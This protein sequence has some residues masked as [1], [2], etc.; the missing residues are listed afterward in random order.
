MKLSATTPSKD[1]ASDDNLVPLINIVFLMLIFFM[2]A[3]QI[4]ASDAVK[5]QAPES[6]T[7]ARGEEHSVTILVAANSAMYLDNL[8]V[9]PDLLVEKLESLLGE[10]DTPDEVSVLVKA[11]AALPVDELQKV[12][13]HIKKAGLLK[14]AL[15]TRQG[16]AV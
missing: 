2:V 16:D 4:T 1:L 8:E 11:D 12:L 10:A 3:G 15:L 13:R 9:S 6:L 7:A 14:V 5:V